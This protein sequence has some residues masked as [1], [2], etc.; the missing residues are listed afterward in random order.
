MLGVLSQVF[1]HLLAG[2]VPLVLAPA[3]VLLGH[4]GVVE[5]GSAEATVLV[6]V[7]EVH[8]QAVLVGSLPPVLLHGPLVSGGA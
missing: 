2:V 8:L 6:G 4:V 3:V 5:G 1:E 7:V